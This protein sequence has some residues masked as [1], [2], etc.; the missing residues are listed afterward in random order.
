MRTS[1]ALFRF[2]AAVVNP[3]I[4]MTRT[5]PPIRLHFLRFDMSFPL[6]EW[7]TH[8]ALQRRECLVIVV[9]RVDSVALGALVGRARLSQVDEC[10][11]A[12]AVTILRELELDLR[13]R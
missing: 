7:A 8:S 3:I 1:V 5:P 2:F 11:L 4:A 12:I 10:R 13:L 6:S 9:D